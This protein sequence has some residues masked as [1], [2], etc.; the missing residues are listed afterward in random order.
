MHDRSDDPEEPLRVYRIQARHPSASLSTR[1]IPD[2]PQLTDPTP[3]HSDAIGPSLKARRARIP[4]NSHAAEW[5]PAVAV[6][7]MIEANP[8]ELW[9]VTL[10]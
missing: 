2:G 5:I 10:G 8:R 9:S 4:Q 1:R 3:A 6:A 7:G